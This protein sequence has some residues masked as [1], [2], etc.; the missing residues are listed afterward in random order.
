MF[1]FNKLQNMKKKNAIIK[2]LNLS[3]VLSKTD[4]EAVMVMI[5]W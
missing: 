5:V 3:L 1:L 4:Q 2:Q